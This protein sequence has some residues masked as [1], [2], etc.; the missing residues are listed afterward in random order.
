MKCGVIFW[1]CVLCVNLDGS[2]LVSAGELELAFWNV[3]NLF[4]TKDDPGVEGD[5]EFTPSGPKQWT[6]HRVAIKLANLTRVIGDMNEQRGPEVLGLCEIENRSILDR[7]IGELNRKT[8]RRYQAVHAESPSFRG[9]D[10]ALLFDAAVATLQ[11]KQ[12]HRIP[13]L[14]TR[15]IVEAELLIGTHRLFVFV[16]HWPSRAN[17]EDDRVAAATVLRHRVDEL[18]R[19]DTACDFVIIGDLNDTPTDKAVSRTLRTWSDPDSLHPGVLLNSMWPLHTDRNRGTYVY[20]NQWQVIDHV[21]LS[22]GMLDSDGLSWKRGSTHEVKADYQMYVSSR[23]DRIPVP[24]RSYTGPNFHSN[25][26]SDH[27]PVACRL[28]WDISR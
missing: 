8:G 11:S 5:E 16:N 22:Q 10:C 15:E 27:L 20:R 17:P 21:I 14:T 19:A 7:L 24:S 6:E 26:Y 12:F 13:E 4:D 2:S 18:L 25:G 9:I 28:V 23:D 3:E 1:L